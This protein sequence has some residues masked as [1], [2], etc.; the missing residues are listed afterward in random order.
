MD[1]VLDE[2]LSQFQTEFVS[3]E[4]YFIIDVENWDGTGMVK[5][6]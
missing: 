3:V 4:G 2:K 1:E 5:W 6:L